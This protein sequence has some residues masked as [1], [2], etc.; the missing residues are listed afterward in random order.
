MLAALTEESARSNQ[1]TAKRAA[2]ILVEDRAGFVVP[3]ARQRVAILMAFAR[4]EQVVYGKAFDIV[5]K[6]IGMDLDDSDSIYRRIDELLVCEIKSTNNTAVKTK[7]AGYFFAITAGEMLTA[8]SLGDRYRFIF[9]N[10]LTRE[11]LDLTLRDIFSR[12]RGIYP[13]WSVRF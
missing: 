9:V 7:F 3:T 5:R 10:T 2:Q 4:D 1:R 11:S 13:T 12:S 8:Q 6:P